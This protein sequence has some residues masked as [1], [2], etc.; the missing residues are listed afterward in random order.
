V[1]EQKHIV[2]FLLFAPSRLQTQS[3]DLPRLAAGLVCAADVA[4]RS[5]QFLFFFS[6]TFLYFYFFFLLFYFGRDQ[7]MNARVRRDIKDRA[8]VSWARVG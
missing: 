1:R 7:A 4:Q 6:F 8:S 5:W 2:C 3:F